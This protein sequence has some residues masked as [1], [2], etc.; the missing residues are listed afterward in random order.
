MVFMDFS[1]SPQKGAL[2]RPRFNYA[3]V[4]EEAGKI[5]YS[6]DIVPTETETSTIKFGNDSSPNGSLSEIG[7]ERSLSVTM[8]PS[9]TLEETSMS[10]QSVAD[11]IRDLDLKPPKKSQSLSSL[12]ICTSYSRKR[13]PKRND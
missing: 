2:V 4:I 7:D 5:K 12:T 10:L 1:H 11:S 8:S 13:C 3:N 9:L 6:E